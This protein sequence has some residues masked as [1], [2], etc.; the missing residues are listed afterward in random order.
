MRMSRER[1]GSV[2]MRSG[3]KRIGE[4]RGGVT[5]RRERK[6]DM[7]NSSGR[8]ESM[9]FKWQDERDHHTY[10]HSHHPLHLLPYPYTPSQDEVHVGVVGARPCRRPLDSVDL[11]AMCLEVMDTCVLS[12]WPDLGEREKEAMLVML[13]SH[14]LSS[15]TTFNFLM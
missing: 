7:R 12:H 10:T 11:F 14:S 6:G 9:G 1:K 2:R 8:R 15:S 3:S 4:R 13:H 5:M